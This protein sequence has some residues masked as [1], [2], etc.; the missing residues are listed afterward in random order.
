MPH[1]GHDEVILDELWSFVWAKRN[2]VWIWIVL[3]RRNLQ[4]LAFFV[5]RRD[6]QS[7]EMV[8]KQVPLPWRDDLVFTDGYRVYQSLLQKAPLQH[9]RCLKRDPET[10]GE[11]SPVEGTNNA[12]RQGVSTSLANLWRLR[13]RSTGSRLDSTGSSITGTSDKPKN[14]PNTHS[15]KIPEVQVVKRPRTW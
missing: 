13:A 5:G 12:L 3:S 1:K 7:A 15:E 9:A 11:T 8:W 10:W 2:A 14:T 4:V 6:L